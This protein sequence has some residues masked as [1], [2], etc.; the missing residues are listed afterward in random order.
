MDYA[1]AKRP[2]NLSLRGD[3]IDAA[4]AAGINLS[5]LLERALIEELVRVKW[6]QWR[7]ENASAL[8]AY[9]RYVT[10]QGAFCRIG[11][12]WPCH[13]SPFT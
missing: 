7:E 6:R 12:R 3:L 8:A 10:E 11:L 4:R 1:G 2:I 13:S 9:N 5:A